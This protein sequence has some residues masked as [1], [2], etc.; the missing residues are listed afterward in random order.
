MCDLDEAGDV[1]A[2]GDDNPV[3]VLDV[4]M[5][6][7]WVEGGLEWLEGIWPKVKAASEFMLASAAV[8][9]HGLPWHMTNTNDEH[10]VIGDVNSCV[11]LFPHLFYVTS[12]ADTRRSCILRRVLHVRDWHARLETMN[13]AGNA[14]RG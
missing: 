5:N 2:R 3:F 14:L 10:G 6:Y 4:Y 8:G 9:A 7:K 1:G 11:E 13:L 12:C